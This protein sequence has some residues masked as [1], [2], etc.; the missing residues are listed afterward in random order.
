MENVYITVDKFNFVD[1]VSWG[2]IVEDG[3]AVA[4]FEFTEDIRAYQYVDGQIVL[5]EE[6]LELLKQAELAH[7]EIYELQ[8]FLD[9]SQTVVTQAFEEEMLGIASDETEIIEVIKRRQQAKTRITE[10]QAAV[11]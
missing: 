6:R 5:D 11:S 9:A 7:T 4:D 10:L 1:S 8:S 3:I 2:G